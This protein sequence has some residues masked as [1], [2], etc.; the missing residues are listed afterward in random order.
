MRATCSAAKSWTI[1]SNSS[2][3]LRLKGGCPDDSNLSGRPNEEVWSFLLTA[4][5]YWT[6]SHGCKGKGKFGGNHASRNLGCGRWYP[7]VHTQWELCVSGTNLPRFSCKRMWRSSISAKVVL[8][9]RIS[10]INTLK[11]PAPSQ[12]M[13]FLRFHPSIGCYPCLY[14]IVIHFQ[15]P[16]TTH[17]KWYRVWKIHGCFPHTLRLLHLSR[18]FLWINIY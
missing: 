2:W 5:F 17:W 10:S 13:W 9:Q 18:R 1:W 8:F 3:R 7:R 4:M 15:F 11:T 6:I 12:P 14:H 16:G